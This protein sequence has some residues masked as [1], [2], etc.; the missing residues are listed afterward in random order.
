MR[1]YFS[2]LKVKIA[3]VEGAY[4]GREERIGLGVRCEIH[5]LVNSTNIFFKKEKYNKAS[6]NRIARK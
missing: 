5:K 2:L 3:R 1:F 6:N 4:E